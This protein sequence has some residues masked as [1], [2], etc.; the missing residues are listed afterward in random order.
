MVI[1]FLKLLPKGDIR[2]EPVLDQILRRHVEWIGLHLDGVLPGVERGADDRVNLSDLP[3]GHRETAH[4]GADAMHHDGAAGVAQGAVIGVGVADV[5]SKIIARIGVQL[6][7]I[8]RI[9]T[10]GNLA[11][12]LA[13]LGAEL[14]RPAAHRKGFQVNVTPVGAHLPDFQLRFLLI[15]ADESRRFLRRAGLFH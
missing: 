10:L 7:R 15:G 4:R 13:R 9:E 6:A 5:E 12:A 3:I 14:A 11:V 2:I 1:A 8:D